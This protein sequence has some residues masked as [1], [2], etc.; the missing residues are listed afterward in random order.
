MGSTGPQ[1]HA[2]INT[3][4][5]PEHS[6][7]RSGSF[8]PI[9]MTENPYNI[10]PEIEEFFTKQLAAWPMAADNFAALEGVKV[11]NLPGL[12]IMDFK[13]QY[14]PARRVSS[15]A[16]VDAD[17]LKARK[18]FL[19]GENRP[20]EQFP[21]PWG[22]YEILINP[23][24]I[25]PRHLTIP[26]LSHTPQR[27]LGRLGDMCRLALKLRGMT[28]FYNGPR[29]GASAPDHMHFQAGNT[30]FMTLP[31]LLDE[32]ADVV[33][34]ESPARIWSLAGL[35][36]GVAVI[37]GR[38]IAEIESIFSDLY[39]A[40][41]VPDGEEEPMMNILCYAP[42]G[43]PEGTVRVVVIPRKKH[44]PAF[45]GTEGDAWLI[46]P[47]SVDIGGAFITPREEDFDRIDQSTVRTVLE[48]C[49]CTA[50]EVEQIIE[51]L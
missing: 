49:C 46:S 36:L 51:K 39:N 31:E 28:V 45:Y 1:S 24:P 7:F 42:A 17:S 32:Y 22:E 48:E 10:S 8:F 34:P 15:A 44:R 18:C 27:I 26:A 29:C 3:N 20:A 12:G 9:I 6:R 4:S 14:N 50:K 40:L 23:F 21:E 2:E 38:N 5:G 19:C 37:E 41:P 25:F 11:K 13:V 35:P 33:E 43:Q 16:K 47:A 30:G